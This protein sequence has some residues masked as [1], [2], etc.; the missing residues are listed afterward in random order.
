[1]IITHHTGEFIKASFGDIVLAFNPISKKSKL[2]AT[3]F[4]ADIA[5]VS[6]DHPDCNGTDEVTRSGKD[7]FTIQGPG[8]YEVRGVFIRGVASQS[9]HGGSPLINT[10]YAVQM[11]DMNI[12]FLGALAETKPDLSIVED[13][14]S[15]D[16]LFVPIGG[17]GVLEAADAHALSVAL[18]ARIIIPIHYDGVG[19]KGALKT[20]L[21]EAGSEDTKAI[22]K[23]TIKRKDLE[24]K[25]GEVIVLK[26]V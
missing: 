19:N 8:E 4:G 13:M 26:S 20:F 7:I 9:E 3:R 24:T 21:K 1:M 15:V 10:M 12:V 11:E 14:D 23:L 18:E 2:S 25:T 6:V 5:L 22:E 16:I 17:D